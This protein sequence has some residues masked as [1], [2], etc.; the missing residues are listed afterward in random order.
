MST[1]RQHVLMHR[2]KVVLDVGTSDP[3]DLWALFLLAGHPAVEVQA[4]VL[5]PGTP[6]QLL[7]VHEALARLA[8]EDAAVGYLSHVPVGYFDVDDARGVEDPF[9]GTGGQPCADLFPEWRV[10]VLR[11]QGPG[12]RRAA[13]GG[14]AR[15]NGPGEEDDGEAERVAAWKR[16]D[17]LKRH[18]L[19]KLRGD[20]I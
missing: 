2:R 7:L 20:E 14:T 13:G 18:T 10:E 6:A 8:T 1:A 3:D 15:K 19:A 16:H 4:V 12:G 17:R 5:C 9:A 11:V